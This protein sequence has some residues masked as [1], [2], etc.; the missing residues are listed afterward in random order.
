MARRD[1]TDRQTWLRLQESL[2]RFLMEHPEDFRQP[3]DT[4]ALEYLSENLAD[5]VVSQFK[6]DL[7][8]DW[9]GV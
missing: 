3:I 4:Q 2:F 6:V 7:R 8:G 5:V 9:R 1:H